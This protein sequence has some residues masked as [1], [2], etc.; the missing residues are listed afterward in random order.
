MVCL[1][2]VTIV[3]RI[4][5]LG[6]M[7]RWLTE[8]ARVTADNGIVLLTTHGLPAIRTISESQQHRNMFGM[9]SAAAEDLLTNF[10]DL[11]FVYYP[12]EADVMD[13]AKAGSD[14]GNAFITSATSTSS[15][16][17]PALK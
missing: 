16:P 4:C 14:Y 7:Q 13:V 1:S 3:A 17:K 12:Y 6:S 11:Q 15:G 5:K 10:D 9:T 8:L 2:L